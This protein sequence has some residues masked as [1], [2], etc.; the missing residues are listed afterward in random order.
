MYVRAKVSFD[1]G[2]TMKPMKQGEHR[3]ISN[4][5]AEKLI[6]LD[7]VEENKP[8]YKKIKFK[9]NVTPKHKA[10]DKS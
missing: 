8:S 6:F 5:L 1:R 2:N 10:E 7:L 3:E 4:E 9:K